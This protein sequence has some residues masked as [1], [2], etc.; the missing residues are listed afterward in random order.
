MNHLLP[1]VL[2]FL[3]FFGSCI[4]IGLLLSALVT[5][6]WITAE[7][8][9]KNPSGNATKFQLTEPTSQK[10][11][12]IQFGLFDYQESLN[13]GYGSRHANYSIKDI[14]NTE[15]NFMD[16]TLWLLTALGTGFSLFSSAV[17]AVSSVVGTIRQH[18]GTIMMFVSNIA[19]AIGST[20][21]VVCW[22]LQFVNHLQ[23][24]VLLMD[25]KT[26]K[27]KAWTTEG[28]STFGFSFFFMIAAFLLVM[29]NLI[30]LTWASRMQK[31]HRKSLEPIEEKEGNSIML[32]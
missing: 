15:K 7:I 23:H 22:I 12:H 14:L 10:R 11:G 6:C 26:Q 24:N 20:I 3:T 30:L 29:L 19:S 8:T 9:Y 4:V 18:G 17:A 31:R 5:N 13:H 32:Y 21:A 25:A 16:H 27:Q 1:K 28:L 2:I